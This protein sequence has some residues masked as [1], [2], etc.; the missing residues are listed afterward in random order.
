MHFKTTNV[1]GKLNQKAL[2]TA[3]FLF[4]FSHLRSVEF[5]EALALTG[6]QD[7]ITH[8]DV[9][10]MNKVNFIP[11]DLFAVHEVSISVL[12]IILASSM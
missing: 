10:G 7:V 4:P 8:K 9:P 11:E 12:K 1:A 5:S 3:V 2:P 6:V